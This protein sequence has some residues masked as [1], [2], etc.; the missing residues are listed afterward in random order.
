MEL[1]LESITLSAARRP[2]SSLSAKMRFTWVWASSNVPLMPQTA[3][4]SPV[5][6]TIC[7]CW[8]SETLPSG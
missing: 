4:L 8:T 7:R 2:A 5:W 6:V 3:T 1:A